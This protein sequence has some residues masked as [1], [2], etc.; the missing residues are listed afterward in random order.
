M[1]VRNPGGGGG[2]GGGTTIIQDGGT[3]IDLSDYQTALPPLGPDE[4]WESDADSMVEAVP[5]KQDEL[6]PLDPGETIEADDM[7]DIVAVP[8]TRR[9]FHQRRATN[10]NQ[11][12]TGSGTTYEVPPRFP[13]VWDEFSLHRVI[14]AQIIVNGTSDPDNDA[15]WK[16]EFQNA[17]GAILAT[18]S[19]YSIN[20][21]GVW[22][23]RGGLHK[24]TKVVFSDQGEAFTMTGYSITFYST[25]Q[26]VSA[27]PDVDL[28]A[29]GETLVVGPD[30]VVSE[31][32]SA[33]AGGVVAST[34][35]YRWDIDAAQ[36]NPG[37]LWQDDDDNVWL[38]E[39]SSDR[40]AD[41]YVYNTNGVL[42]AR[43]D[44]PDVDIPAC[45]FSDG[46]TF[47]V[48]DSIATT[49]AARAYEVPDVSAAG[50]DVVDLTRKAAFDVSK[51][52][53]TRPH[54]MGGQT[55]VLA[56]VGTR[57]G[58]PRIERWIIGTDG[59][60]STSAFNLL[61]TRG[62]TGMVVDGQEYFSMIDQPLGSGTVT[63]SVI[64]RAPLADL[65][66]GQ[67]VYI[68]PRNAA[69][70]VTFRL[71]GL[72]RVDGIWRSLD[73]VDN[74]VV[75]FDDQGRE[76]ESGG[77]P[78]AT[79]GTLGL[80]RLAA[81]DDLEP[82]SLTSEELVVTPAGLDH[83]I[84]GHELADE[85]RIDLAIEE[86]HQLAWESMRA[87]I[88]L[89]RP[90]TSLSLYGLDN[91]GR[92][93]F[94]PHMALA[95]D[96]DANF[97]VCSDRQVWYA[98][99]VT[100]TLLTQVGGDTILPDNADSAA[101][102]T[103]TLYV[104]GSQRRLMAVDLGAGT[105]AY[106]GASNSTAGTLI[107]HRRKLY[108]VASGGIAEVDPADGSATLFTGSLG[109]ASLVLEAVVSYLGHIWLLDGDSQ[110]WIRISD[111]EGVIT[112][113]VQAG[114]EVPVTWTANLAETDTMVE[115][116]GRIYSTHSV[117]GAGRL[118]R[119]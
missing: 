7:G 86:A 5:K 59:L 78:A 104:I 92:A 52:N 109:S 81:D 32:P 47:W 53:L 110:E 57:G 30:G 43:Y 93:S 21:P 68:T 39:A 38:S 22:V 73:H 28:G 34:V 18:I 71:H 6:P 105:A 33:G 15:P 79:T 35:R 24:T 95:S 118:G 63:H 11:A 96:V 108:L 94:N 113:Q 27:A 100:G 40:E 97:F 50:D 25:P 85:D 31:P 74:Q 62:P 49:H 46:T 65:M 29:E 107:A 103:G 116:R 67:G 99:P 58:S 45:V 19:G 20:H 17:D 2:K 51:G 56:V 87:G 10:V 3:P 37:N 36:T 82:G 8:S 42:Q 111:D 115:W 88:Q 119:M 55:N 48:V 4:T 117:S 114:S 41:L 89:G 1:P 23:T 70:G 72:T 69:E 90:P 44:A 26:P 64:H 54:S 102:L 66:A 14:S 112:H 60:T 76:L 77:V 12:F 84:V 91:F 101:Y 13:P 83:V 16:V 61:N 9:I 80:V 98:D 106:V 75:A